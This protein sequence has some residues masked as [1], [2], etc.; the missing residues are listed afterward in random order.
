MNP[1]LPPSDDDD[2]SA[3]T[4]TATP[5]R[6]SAPG[7]RAIPPCSPTSSA[8]VSLPRLSVNRSTP[9]LPARNRRSRRPLSVLDGSVVP[10]PA[11]GRPLPPPPTVRPVAAAVE[12]LA[13][14]GRCCHGRHRG[15]GRRRALTS[16]DDDVA[17]PTTEDRVD[18]HHGHQRQLGVS[19]RGRRTDFAT[20]RRTGCR[21]RFL[22]RHRRLDRRGRRPPRVGRARARPHRQPP[23]PADRRRR[24]HTPPPWPVRTSSCS[25]HRSPKPACSPR[26]PCTPRPTAPSSAPSASPDDGQ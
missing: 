14:R 24:P 3:P 4:S 11:G 17:S 8:F 10:F 7:W 2:S 12:P 1:P 20:G 5:P 6:P 23:V 21:P 18:G 13:R 15:G 22:R 19:P 9:T 26:A 25:W 16:G